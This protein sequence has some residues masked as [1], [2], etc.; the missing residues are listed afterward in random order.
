MASDS[1]QPARVTDSYANVERIVFGLAMI[2][3]PILMLGAA[4]FHPPHGIENAAGYYSAS[5]DHSMGFY[6]AHTCFF[7]SAVLFVLAIVG[8]ARLVHPSHPKAAFWGCVLSLMGFIGYG[9]L[10]GIDYMAWVAGKPDTGLDPTTMQRYI[11]VVLTTNAILVPVLLVF[12]LLPIGLI[13]LAVGVARAGVLPGW[14]AALMPLGM[15]GVA[16]SLQY[17]PLL[18]ISALALLASFGFVGL[19]LLRAPS[20]ALA[21]ERPV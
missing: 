13:V 11:E 18:V 7:L 16:G 21:E 4:I 15:V 9:A 3:A 14:L 8:L 17:P 6:V 10:D 12:T 5:H 1:D 2:I 20:A 19:R